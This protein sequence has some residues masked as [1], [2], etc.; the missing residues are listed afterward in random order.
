MKILKADFRDIS[1]CCFKAG[2][3][4]S[5]RLI[6]S[7]AHVEEALREFLEIRGIIGMNDTYMIARSLP[8][9]LKMKKQLMKYLHFM[10][11][12]RTR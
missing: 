7:L 6:V 1:L 3:L 8:K 2:C 4:E 9:F 5:R 10:F 12:L 11:Q